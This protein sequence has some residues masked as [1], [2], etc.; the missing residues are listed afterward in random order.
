MNRSLFSTFRLF[1][2]LKFEFLSTDYCCKVLFIDGLWSI[3]DKWWVLL[4]C[5]RFCIYLA[6]MMMIQMLLSG[7]LKIWDLLFVI[8]HV[9]Y[10]CTEFCL[11]KWNWKKW[12][13]CVSLVFF[14][15]LNIFLNAAWGCLMFLSCLV[16][17]CKQQTVVYVMKDFPVSR[18]MLQ[19]WGW[20]S[21]I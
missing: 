16:Q 5:E 11:H 18:A 2:R 17:K 13:S 12:D 10:S 6:K 1:L 4:R 15:K 14:W 19:A 21:Y 20:S 3:N 7:C 8:F 9:L